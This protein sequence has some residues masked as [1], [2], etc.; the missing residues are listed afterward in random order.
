MLKRLLTGNELTSAHMFLV[1]VCFRDWIPLVLLVFFKFNQTK[2][3]AG[4]DNF[5]PSLESQVTS[6]RLRVTHQAQVLQKLGK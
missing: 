5:E 3:Q 1:L 4:Q 2:P 6:Q